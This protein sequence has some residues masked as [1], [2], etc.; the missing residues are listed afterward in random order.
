MD[1]FSTVRSE[2]FVFKMAKEDEPVLP[3]YATKLAEEAY[4]RLTQ[5]YGFVPQGPIQVEIFPDHGGFAV[6]TLGLPGL[7]ALGVCF[8]KVLALDSPRAR[9]AGDFNWGTTLW[10]E[11]THVITL[12]MTQYNIP[13]WYSEGLSVYEEER[14]RPGWGDDLTAA[15]MKAYK[16]GKLLKVSELNAGMMRPDS[17]EQIELS[18]YQAALFCTMIE[19]KFGF[20]KI[21]QSLALYAKNKPTEEV[22]RETLGWDARALDAQYAAF[23]DT[24]LKALAPRLDFQRLAADV[25]AKEPPGKPALEAILKKNPDDFFANLQLGTELR[26][27]KDARSAEIYLK[28]AESLFPAFVEP[29]NPYEL[30]G[31]LYLERGSENEALAQFIGLVSYDETAV[32]P[33]AHAAEIY[34]KRKDWADE[35]K[36][37][38]LSVYIDPYDTQVQAL[39]GESAV[40]AENWTS[41]IAA[42]QVLLG[43]NPQDPA[44]AHYNLA[45]AFFGAGKKAE[46]KHEVLRAL[47]IAPTFEKAQEL[48]LKINGGI[49]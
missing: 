23:L 34:R 38:E 18:Y 33:L 12:Q 5:R 43:L 41:A 48:L 1:K 14:A 4:S 42:Y 3:P 25:V 8:G 9:K 44:G 45:R 47:E 21:K 22:F 17:P 13:R 10:H 40:N 11:F 28:K 35:T 36:M 15:F 39:L 26:Q 16:D 31:D 20:D 27:E 32:A 7:D 37:L 29:G 2:H 24:K 6:R 19:E 46:A 30:L 49:R